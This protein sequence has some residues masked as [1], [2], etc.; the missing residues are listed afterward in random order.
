MYYVCRYVIIL[1]IPNFYK[2]L[3]KSD[4]DK[5]GPN[6]LPIPPSCLITVWA[7]FNQTHPFNR[8]IYIAFPH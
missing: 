2:Q 1:C 7:D 4:A 6:D 8:N 3:M 5:F